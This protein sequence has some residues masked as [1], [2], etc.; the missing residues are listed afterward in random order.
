MKTTE[1]LSVAVRVATKA[2][3]VRTTSTNATTERH[4]AFKTKESATT[5][6]V[7]THASVWADS[8]EGFVEQTLMSAHRIL[9]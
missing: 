4:I 8:L 3:D 9:V 6:K 5:R 1:T 7:R 2:T